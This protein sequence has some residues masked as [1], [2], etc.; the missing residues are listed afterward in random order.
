MVRT[1]CAYLDQRR[2]LT[3]ELYVVPPVYHLVRVRAEVIADGNADL[4]E[5]KRG[6][7]DRLLTY[8]HPLRGGEEGA[9]WEFGGDVF[10]SLVY[11]QVLSVP[12]VRRIEQL[13]IE[14]DGEEQP[15]CRDVPIEDGALVYS[16]EHEIVVTYEVAG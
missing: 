2:L 13:V 5:V 8:F 6:V 10:F 3:T 11:R 12:G 1:V 14:L 9:G 4:A 15:F 7:E 16:T